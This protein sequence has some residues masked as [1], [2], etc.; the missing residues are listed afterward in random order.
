ML[1]G[2][3]GKYWDDWRSLYLE[4]VLDLLKLPSNAALRCLPSTDENLRFLLREWDSLI[5]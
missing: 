1:A 5:V 2:T 3:E 4:T